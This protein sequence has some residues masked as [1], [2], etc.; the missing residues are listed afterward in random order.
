MIGALLNIPAEAAGSTT[1]NEDLSLRA[2]NPTEIPLFAADVCSGQAMVTWHIV[3][4][5]LQE[6][7]IFTEILL[8][9]QYGTN[10]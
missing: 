8:L 2:V 3:S 9:F 10:E 7:H 4:K 1:L 6:R 5:Y